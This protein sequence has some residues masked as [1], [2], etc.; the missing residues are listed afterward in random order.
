MREE[1]GNSQAMFGAVVNDNSENALAQAESD[2]SVRGHSVFFALRTFEFEWP[3]LRAEIDQEI[4]H[5]REKIVLLKGVVDVQP[6]LGALHQPGIL[7]DAE[8]LRDR[9]LAHVEP[10]RYLTCRQSRFGQVRQHSPAHR[11]RKSLKYFPR[12]YFLTH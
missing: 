5:S 10:L 2:L 3:T 6:L 11:R 8:M 9:G 4:V 12:E 7:K 1:M